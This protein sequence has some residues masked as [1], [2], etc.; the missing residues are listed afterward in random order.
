MRLL[1]SL[2]SLSEAD[3]LRRSEIGT[4]RKRGRWL[5]FIL[6]PYGEATSFVRGEAPRVFDVM[7]RDPLTITAEHYA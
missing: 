1:S 5:T 4:Q 6:G 2:A 7:T 3:F